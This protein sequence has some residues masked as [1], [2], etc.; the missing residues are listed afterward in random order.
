[1]WWPGRSLVFSRRFLSGTLSRCEA[2]RAKNNRNPDPHERHWRFSAGRD[3]LAF[4]ARLVCLLRAGGCRLSG[5]RLVA[6]AKRCE[7]LSAGSIY[8]LHGGRVGQRDGGWII[9]LPDQ[10]VGIARGF[11]ALDRSPA[12]RRDL[13]G[14]HDADRARRRVLLE[15]VAAP[16]SRRGLRPENLF[17]DRLLTIS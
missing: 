3:G 9:D 13:A 14:G 17:R 5:G 7:R 15:P 8:R 11:F 2:G 1:M 10:L 6:D 16:R 4:V 12:R